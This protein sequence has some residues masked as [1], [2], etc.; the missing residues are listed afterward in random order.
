MIIRLNETQYNTMKLLME[1]AQAN[2]EKA[3]RDY[4]RVQRR[5]N[6]EQAIRFIGDVKHDIPNSRLAKSKFMLGVVRIVCENNVVSEDIIKFNTL[7]KYIASDAHVNEYDRNLNGLTYDEIN[8]RFS[9]IMANNVSAERNEL[10]SM[11]YTFNQ[12]YTI[13][14]IKSHE[15]AKAY[16]KYT[17]WCVTQQESLYNTYTYDGLGL[18]YFCLKNG[19]EQVPKEKGEGCPLDEYG[20]SMIA[21]S[22]TPEG[23]PNT[24]TCRWNHENG[25]SDSVMTPKQL[26]H[27]IGRNFYE[28]FPPKY[29]EQ[30]LRKLG[31][32]SKD[33]VIEILE[34]NGDPNQCAKTIKYLLQRNDEDIKKY[35]KYF[36]YGVDDNDEVHE[37]SSL[38]ELE[39]DGLDREWATEVLYVDMGGGRTL[40]N[41]VIYDDFGE[42]VPASDV[43]VENF[44]DTNFESIFVLKM[45]DGKYNIIN[46]IRSSKLILPKNADRVL[47]DYGIFP[48][49]GR[50]GWYGRK[51][52][53]RIVFVAEYDKKYA[54]FSDN[55]EQLSDFY[56]SIHLEYRYNPDCPYRVRN[57]DNMDNVLGLDGKPYLPFWC[58]YISNPPSITK[59]KPGIVKYNGLYHFVSPDGNKI[60]GDKNGY[61]H[62]MRAYEGRFGDKR[63]VYI[64]EY[65][66]GGKSYVEFKNGK[67]IKLAI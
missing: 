19:F 24:I 25:G 3:A 6:D 55:G 38:N 51:E 66:N 43:W 42:P 47:T 36:C 64:C 32:V 26:S 2:N 60:I 12:D 8:L 58:D 46:G 28:V 10:S 50:S 39:R 40:Q 48:L 54:L 17:T 23:A 35:V 16:A 34:N 18:F 61:S 62:I 33:E 56:K 67:V 22:I 7:L 52:A 9:T 1:G 30:E 31:Y 65:V 59:N 21:V 49:E 20:L 45:P 4:L 53:Q 29:T 5:L 13:V 44:Y 15:E 41:P 11:N 14:P 57:F 27:L 63:E 37:Y